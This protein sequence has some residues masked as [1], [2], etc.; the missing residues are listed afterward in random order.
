V[1]IKK[2]QRSFVE[3]DLETLLQLILA[4]NFLNISSLLDVTCQKTAELIKGKSPQ[5]IR[6]TF[7]IVVCCA[8]SVYQWSTSWHA[9]QN[10]AAEA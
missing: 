2:T 8:E 5:E 1:Q 9:Q 7:N 3:V 6:E 10:E 4:A